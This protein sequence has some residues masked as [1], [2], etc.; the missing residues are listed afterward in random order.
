MTAEAADRL[1]RLH[2]TVLGQ[3]PGVLLVMHHVI[4]HAK[5]SCSVTG[6]Q[7]VECLGVTGLAS[8]HQIEFRDIGLSRSRFRMHDWTERRLIHST[9]KAFGAE[10]PEPLAAILAHEGNNAVAHLEQSLFEDGMLLWRDDLLGEQLRTRFHR[11][12]NRFQ[13]AL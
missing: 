10:A 5:N 8:F 9:P 12:G 7:L 13:C 2:E 1:P 4:D 6:N 3:I 11:D